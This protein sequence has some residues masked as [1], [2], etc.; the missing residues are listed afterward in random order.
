MT[1]KLILNFLERDFFMDYSRDTRGSI[2]G[3]NPAIIKRGQDIKFGRVID[4]KELAKSEFIDVL[5]YQTELEL[6]EQEFDL[7]ELLKKDKD[8]AKWLDSFNSYIETIYHETIPTD[9]SI[10][11]TPFIPLEYTKFPND[12]FDR[13]KEGYY[14]AP[15]GT[16]NFVPEGIYYMR[17]LP[18]MKFENGK[19]LPGLYYNRKVIRPDGIIEGYSIKE[20][21]TERGGAGVFLGESE[22]N[23][24]ETCDEFEG[25]FPLI[26]FFE[27]VYPAPL[28]MAKELKPLTIQV[29]LSNKK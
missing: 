22:K 1:K 4:T 12:Y 10:E 5:V 7:S 13:A 2:K 14:S 25:G 29:H 18:P 24:I 9:F 26:H 20:K 23:D 6:A 19:W 11:N 3:Y 28:R 27:L 16:I 21:S 17:I 8:G 15:R